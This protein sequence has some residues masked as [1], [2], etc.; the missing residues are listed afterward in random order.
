MTPGGIPDIG[1]DEW[2]KQL[3]AHLNRSNPF[4]GQRE[5]GTGKGPGFMGAVPNPYQ[6]GI[7]GE[8]SIGIDPTIPQRG[9]VN[10]NGYSYN[11]VPSM[12]PTLSPDE[13]QWM[14][15]GNP[16]TAAIRKKAEAFAKQRKTQGKGPFRGWDE[17]TQYP[18]PGSFAP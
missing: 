8:L 14:L 13:L 18:L 11:S 4:Y 7:S 17:D 2:L 9:T 16:A 6:G 5:D 1:R 12:V 3:A 10:E 15:A